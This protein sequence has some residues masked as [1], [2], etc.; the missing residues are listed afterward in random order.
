[1]ILSLHK[2]NFVILEFQYYQ[3]IKQPLQLLEL[4]EDSLLFWNGELK[5]DL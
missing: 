3:P 5:P 2:T 1:M 4:Y